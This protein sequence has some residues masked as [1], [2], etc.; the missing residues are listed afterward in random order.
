ML[1]LAVTPLDVVKIRLQAQQ[2][3]MLSNKCFLYCNGLMDH[4]CCCGVGKSG[5]SQAAWIK[6][7]GHFSGTMVYLNIIE[8]L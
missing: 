2:K 1:I 3:A 7:N 6:A 8:L 4:I 5:M